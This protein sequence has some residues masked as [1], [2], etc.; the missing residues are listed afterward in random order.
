MA[1]ILDY[2]IIGGG[3]YYL[4]TKSQEQDEDFN[5]ALA[6]IAAGTITYVKGSDI[7][8]SAKDFLKGPNSK[9]NQ[10]KLLGG[11]VLGAAGYAFGDKIIGGVKGGNG[12]P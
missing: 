2:I 6:A 7:Y 1:S 11:L 12:K 9:K 3:A 4:A 5:K 8:D 10:D